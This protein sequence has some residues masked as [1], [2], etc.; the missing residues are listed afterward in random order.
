MQPNRKK[1]PSPFAEFSESR[2][3]HLE[4][5]A[6]LVEQ[7]G[8][9]RVTDVAEQLGLT[10]ATVSNMVRRLAARWIGR[11]APARI[12]I[13][14]RCMLNGGGRVRILRWRRSMRRI[15]KFA[16]CAGHGVTRRCRRW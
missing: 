10:P 7:K 1:V 15:G 2:E 5:I 11:R 16:R 14:A 6:E 12:V 9:A 3:D 4:R 13:V 8:Y